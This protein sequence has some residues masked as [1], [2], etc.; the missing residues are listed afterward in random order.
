MRERRK[1]LGITQAELATTANVSQSRFGYWEKSRMPSAIADAT[2]IALETVLRVPGGWLLSLDMQLL[3]DDGVDGRNT[4]A[5]QGGS[6]PQMRIPPA[7]CREIGPHARRLREELGLS[8]AE[9]ARVCCLESHAN[10]VGAG[11]VSEDAY[12]CVSSRLG[13][14]TPA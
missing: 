9:V 4:I 7:Q 14:S 8:V 11:D 5:R 3:P 2:V 6:Y 10:A 13:A 12:R 1:A